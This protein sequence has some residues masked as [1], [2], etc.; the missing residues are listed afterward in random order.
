M[1]KKSSLGFILIIMVSLLWMLNS[2]PSKEEI[3][4]QKEIRDSIEQVEANLPIVKDPTNGRESKKEEIS[5]QVETA[6]NVEPDSLKL[7]RLTNIHGGLSNSLAK[8]GVEPILIENDKVKLEINPNGGLIQ[9]AEGK[10]YM[11]FDFLPVIPANPTDT[12]EISFF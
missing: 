4:R 11:T 6:Q 1:E 5:E 2:Q 9:Y 10:D 7:A 3:A 12:M 8:E